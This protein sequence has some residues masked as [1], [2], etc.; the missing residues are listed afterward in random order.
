MPSTPEMAS[1]LCAVGMRVLCKYRV[2]KIEDVTMQT[3][4]NREAM[5]S[6]SMLTSKKQVVWILQHQ[7]TLGAS[8]LCKAWLV[9]L[10]FFYIL[11][12]G[13]HRI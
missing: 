2:S 3:M 10:S 12:Y 11:Y 9:P 5:G 8:S 13:V 7:Q 1:H 4:K 6:E